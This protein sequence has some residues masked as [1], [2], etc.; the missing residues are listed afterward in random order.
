LPLLERLTKQENTK[1]KHLAILFLHYKSLECVGDLDITTTMQLVIALQACLP[2][3]NIGLDW[4]EGWVS[5]VIYPGAFSRQN[6]DTDELGIVHQGRANLSGESWQ[7]GPVVLSWG[8]SLR[9]GENDGRNVV[10]HEFA[11]KLD[12]LNGRANGL[13]P[14]HKDMSIQQWS[15]VFNSAYDDFSMR[16]QQNDYIAIDPYAATS[17]AEF[18]AVF[19]EFFFE[20][21]DIIAHYYGD[22]YNLLVRFYRQDPLTA[23]DFACAISTSKNHAPSS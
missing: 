19:S 3:L 18:F 22:V 14:L 8:D 1:L 12:M 13:P 10:I 15:D 5:V 6:I 16:L 4:Y 9:N 17:P 2:I 11:H 23:F 21:P 20:K 7:R